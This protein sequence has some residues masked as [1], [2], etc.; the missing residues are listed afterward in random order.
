M[1]ALLSL[2]SITSGA[3]LRHD[4]LITAMQR[5]RGAAGSRVT[6][7]PRNSSS[8][9]AAAASAYSQ[10]S[11]LSEQRHKAKVSNIL[12][13]FNTNLKNEGMFVMSEISMKPTCSNKYVTV[14]QDS[15]LKAALTHKQLKTSVNSVF[16]VKRAQ[17]VAV[18]TDKAANKL[19]CF[20][21]KGELRLLVCS[22]LF[23]S[24]F[25]KLN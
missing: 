15:L 22:F 8:S 20:N 10:S 4:T 14:V 23:L 24:H 3:S 1:L 11:T 17:S 16:V 21:E 13:Y 5:F 9:S 25:A 2:F 6:T 12:N 19:V 7:T 18:F